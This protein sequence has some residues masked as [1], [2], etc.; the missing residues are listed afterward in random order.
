M[1][2]FSFWF[3]HQSENPPERF[4]KDRGFKS[5]PDELAFLFGRDEPGL[6]EEIEMIGDARLAHGESR[7]NLAGGHVPLFEHSENCA[8]GIVLNRFEKKVH[9]NRGIL[10]LT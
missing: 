8:A 4:I 2:G 10:W 7:G 3:L 5:V 6:L 1:G 9:E